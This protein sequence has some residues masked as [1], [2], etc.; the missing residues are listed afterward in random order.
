MEL[1]LPM[2]AFDNINPL[3]AAGGINA[4]EI[5][6]LGWISNSIVVAVIVTV[7]VLLFTR[8][9]TKRMELIPGSKQNLVE[10]LVEFL[11]GQVEGIVGKHVAPKAFPLLATVF[12]FILASNWFGLLP[13]VGTIGFGVTKA[14]LVLEVM[15]TPLL[16]PATADL[17]MTLALAVVFMAVWAWLSISELGFW[18]TIVH[19]FGPKGGLQGALKYLLTPIFIFVGIIEVVS[20]VFRPMSLSLRLLGN[21]FAGETLLHTMGELGEKIGLPSWMAVITSVVF[22]LPFYFMEILVGALQA[23]VF[24]L[25]CAV[26]IKLATTHDEAAH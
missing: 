5:P 20:I 14:P 10:Y 24:S 12:I 21:I 6:A 11:Y 19:I 8:M 17:N 9:A 25:L 15:E 4:P 7:G 22:P 13:G 1:H 2:F 23:T 3:I 18:G 26:Y 16:R